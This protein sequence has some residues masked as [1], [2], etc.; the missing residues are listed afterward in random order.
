MLIDELIFHECCSIIPDTSIIT[1]ASVYKLNGH[2]SNQ[3]YCTGKL[4]Q[5]RKTREI[6]IFDIDTSI[7]KKNTVKLIEYLRGSEI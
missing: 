2:L 7:Y 6:Y 5:V 4:N 3:G 1:K